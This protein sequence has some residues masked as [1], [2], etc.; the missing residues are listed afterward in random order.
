L[1]RRQIR[2]GVDVLVATPGRLADLIQEGTVY[3]DQVDIVVVDEADRM[4][5]MGFMPQV[6]RLVDLVPAHRQT[7]LFSAT[8]DGEVSELTR[9]YQQNPATHDVGDEP[10]RGDAAHYFWNVQHQDRVRMT[11]DIVSS[12]TPSIVFTRTRRGA[13]RVARQLGNLGV[14]SESI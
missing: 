4:A 2:R 8:L 3:L 1:Q 9:R 12:S 13:D 7:L 6:R 5:D 10:D 11:A 14:R